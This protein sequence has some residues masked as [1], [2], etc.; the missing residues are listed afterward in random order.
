MGAEP[1]F[2]LV[3]PQHRLGVGYP[4]G[5]GHVGRPVQDL[6]EVGYLVLA[7]IAHKEEEGAGVGA[8]GVGEEGAYSFV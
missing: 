2:L 3:A 6:V 5:F 4:S 7:V 8:E 1:Q